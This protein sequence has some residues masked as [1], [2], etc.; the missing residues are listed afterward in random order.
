MPKFIPTFGGYSGP[1]PV[2]HIIAGTLIL[3][4]LAWLAIQLA[5]VG[6]GPQINNGVNAQ[7]VSINNTIYDYQWRLIGMAGALAA[8]YY[9]ARWPMSRSATFMAFVRNDISVVTSN[10]AACDFILT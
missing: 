10:T 5:I 1:K 2:L 9:A 8:S 4:A 7:A 6:F 3:S